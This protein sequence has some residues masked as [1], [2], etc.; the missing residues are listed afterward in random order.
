LWPLV[1]VVTN[2]DDD[3]LEHYGGLPQLK[4]AFE[5]HLRRLPFY[6]AA[7]LCFDDPELRR[8]ARRLTSPVVSYGFNIGSLWR[9]RRLRT[10]TGSVLEIRRKGKKVG[11]LRLKVAGRHNAQNA[12]AAVAVAGFLGLELKRVFAGLE[13]FTG[14]GRRM[15]SL[16]EANGVAFVDDY[17]HHPTEV[18]ATLDAMRER[19]GRRRLVVLFQPHRFSRT[20]ALHRAFGKSFSRADRLFVAD[21][22][23]AGEKPIAGV[24]SKLII[25]AAKRAGVDAAPLGRAIELVRELRAGDVVLTLGAGDIWKTGMDLM[26][27]FGGVTLSDA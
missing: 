17:G 12:L 26:R 9:G 2:I 18:R 19:F 22:Y 1:A 23:A 16:G 3:H 27:R 5:T 21:I 15:E 8:M 6:G 11:R 24:K 13:S 20:K 14:V 10:K 7:I 4:K 25:D